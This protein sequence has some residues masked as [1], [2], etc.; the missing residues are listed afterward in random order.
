MKL[1]GWL[2]E[3]IGYGIGLFETG[4]IIVMPYL[5]TLKWEADLIGIYAVEGAFRLMK[6]TYYPKDV[7]ID[8][9]YTGILPVISIILYN[10]LIENKEQ[11]EG[12]W[13]VL[14]AIFLIFGFL[15]W[16]KNESILL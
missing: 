13:C 4:I 1:L 2:W 16:L 9:L 14:A 8:N 5:I 12:A 11:K 6:D 15:L 10:V 7:I 3:N